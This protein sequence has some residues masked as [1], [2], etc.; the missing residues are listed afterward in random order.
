MEGSFAFD[1]ATFDLATFD[2]ATFGIP[3]FLPPAL[4]FCLPALLPSCLA[5]AW[6]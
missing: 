1:L 2:L 3:T 5:V 4:N 6:S